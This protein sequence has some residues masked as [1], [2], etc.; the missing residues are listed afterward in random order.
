LDKL[1]THVQNF[2][3]HLETADPNSWENIGVGFVATSLQYGGVIK[4]YNDAVRDLGDPKNNPGMAQALTAMG[5]WIKRITD[6]ITT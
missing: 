4:A 5:Q 6:R 2:L 3:D 1:G